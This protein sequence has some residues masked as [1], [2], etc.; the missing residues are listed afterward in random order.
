[1][2]ALTASLLVPNHGRIVH[3][4]RVELSRWCR[5]PVDRHARDQGRDNCRK[6]RRYFEH[7]HWQAVPGEALKREGYQGIEAVEDEDEQLRA[8]GRGYPKEATPNS[9]SIDWPKD[10]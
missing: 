7:S 10:K 8:V 3:Q 6:T 1:M 2:D 5:Y 4:Q 9:C